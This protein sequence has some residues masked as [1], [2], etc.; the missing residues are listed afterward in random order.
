[1]GSWTSSL[2][3]LSLKKNIHNLPRDF[4]ECVHFV[5]KRFRIFREK[6]F[7]KYSIELLTQEQQILNILRIS[8]LLEAVVRNLHNAD[9]LLHQSFRCVF[10][11]NNIE[12]DHWDI[13]K[14]FRRRLY[15]WFRHFCTKKKFSDV[16]KHSE[17]YLEKK[18][19]FWTMSNNSPKTDPLI[20]CH[21]YD[22]CNNFFNNYHKFITTVTQRY[23]FIFSSLDEI[24]Q[25]ESWWWIIRQ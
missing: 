19:F 3:V 17:K 12:L 1:L 23:E 10:L 16:K 21:P 6:N 14:M 11:F 8:Q 15:F 20:N 18:I 9:E 4:F 5:L 25:E 13:S 22:F 24:E 2:C 7:R